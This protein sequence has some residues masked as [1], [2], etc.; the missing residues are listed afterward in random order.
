MRLT[1]G[2]RAFACRLNCV[3]G[4]DPLSHWVL[5]RSKVLGV[6][7]PAYTDC[8][9]LQRKLLRGKR[10]KRD[11][12]DGTSISL[13]PRKNLKLGDRQLAARNEAILDLPNEA[14]GAND[15]NDEECTKTVGEDQFRT[16]STQD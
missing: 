15:A 1:L 10:D 11:K 14:I 12:R 7:T 3:Y 13:G 2:A 4:V 8:L 9:N 5:L 16:G 6:K